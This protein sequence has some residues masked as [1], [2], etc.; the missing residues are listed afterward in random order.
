MLVYNT[1]SSITTNN[2]YRLLIA[3]DTLITDSIISQGII[4][5]LVKAI[6]ADT[7]CV[8]LSRLFFGTTSEK[9]IL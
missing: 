2:K 1:F 8:D 3:S 5:G 6:G 9:I 4:R 7:L